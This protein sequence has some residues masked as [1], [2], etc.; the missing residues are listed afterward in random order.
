MVPSGLDKGWSTH[1]PSLNSSPVSDS[2]SHLAPM[3][4]IN[5]V[6]FMVCGHLFPVKIPSRLVI[7]V[8]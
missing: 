4:A 8:M 1:L 6:E 3:L 2:S 7:E 5:Q